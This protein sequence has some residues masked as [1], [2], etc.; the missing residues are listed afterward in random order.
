M[1]ELPFKTLVDAGIKE[2]ILIT[3]GQQPGSFLELFKN[4]RS[5]GAEK[6]FYAYQSGNAGIGDALKLARPFL[7]KKE[8][9]V[10]I[11]GD[12]YFRDGIGEAHK[13]WRENKFQGAH[14]LLK[15]VDKPWDFGVA[16]LHSHRNIIMSLE[17]KPKDPKSNFAV[18]GCYF[19]DWQVWNYLEDI[20]PSERGEV[21]IID[22]LRGYLGLVFNQLSFSIYNGF[23]KDMG[24]FDSLM[25]VAKK[26]Q[27]DENLEKGSKNV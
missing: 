8:P 9:C 11:L 5:H 13:R 22:V 2:I 18:L 15:E 19:F 27:E 16:E 6:M 12:N 4:G 3:G 23:W 7:R 14:V 20:K 24:T 10:V 1:V 17:E 26:I 21:E 25:E